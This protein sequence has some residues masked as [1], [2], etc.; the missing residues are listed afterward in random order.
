MLQKERVRGVAAEKS[1]K[2]VVGSR[3]FC[4]RE[5]RYET[6]LQTVESLGS[7]TTNLIAAGPLSPNPEAEWC[8]VRKQDATPEVIE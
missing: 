3:T 6:R 5:I 1:E 8:L 4:L 7:E 2:S